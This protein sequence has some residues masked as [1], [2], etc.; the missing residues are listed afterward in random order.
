M[1]LSGQ[2]SSLT[3]A[4]V[5]PTMPAAMSHNYRYSRTSRPPRRL[6]RAALHGRRRRRV[7]AVEAQLAQPVTVPSQAP[8]SGVPEGEPAN[9]TV[10]RRGPVPPDQGRGW[11]ISPPGG[12]RERRGPTRSMRAPPADGRRAFPSRPRRSAGVWGHADR[13]GATSTCSRPPRP[14]APAAR[15]LSYEAVADRLCCI[16][17]PTSSL[18]PSVTVSPSPSVARSV[19]AP[20]A[21]ASSGVPRIIP[22]VALGSGGGT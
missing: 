4:T 15:R 18:N 14:P 19:Y 3:S 1:V 10:P 17:P 16:R 22:P 7:C 12:W 9:R 11:P 2:P 13:A 8:Q 6:Q 21:G 20:P 5:S